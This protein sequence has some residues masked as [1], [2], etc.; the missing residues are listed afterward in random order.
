MYE[1]NLELQASGMYDKVKDRGF[2]RLCL[3]LF[4]IEKHFVL[5]LG[6]DKIM[7]H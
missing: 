7:D 1:N 2:W 5:L 6:V 4:L 3:N